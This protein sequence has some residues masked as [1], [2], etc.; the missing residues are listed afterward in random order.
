MML[1]ELTM[2]ASEWNGDRRGRFGKDGC[3]DERKPAQN[4]KSGTEP[5][6]SQGQHPPHAQGE[7]HDKGDQQQTTDYG[8]RV[9]Q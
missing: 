7:T 1:T 9:Q 4:E 2:A 5:T 8:E 6:P 3:G